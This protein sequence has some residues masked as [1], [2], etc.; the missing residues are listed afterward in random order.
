MAAQTN[1]VRRAAPGPASGA[2]AR[3]SLPPAAGGPPR[4]PGEAEEAG[5]AADVAA[6]NHRLAQVQKIFK[7]GSRGFGG[8]AAI[9]LTILAGVARVEA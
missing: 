2:S 6:G 9:A 5:K 7:G 3:E 4:R 1:Q 8:Q